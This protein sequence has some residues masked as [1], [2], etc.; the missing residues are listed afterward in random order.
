MGK[1]ILKTIKMPY[2]NEGERAT[3]GVSIGIA[4]FSPESTNTEIIN[5][6]AD[7]AM[8][9]AKHGGKGRICVYDPNLDGLADEPADSRLEPVQ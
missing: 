6:H 1:K 9:R 7:T 2:E 3:V 8:Y 5:R 4:Y